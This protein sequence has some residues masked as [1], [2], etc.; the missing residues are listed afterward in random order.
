M[1]RDVARSAIRTDGDVLDVTARVRCTARER[2]RDPHLHDVEQPDEARHDVQDERRA[3]RVHLEVARVG[4]GAGHDGRRFSKAPSWLDG[5]AESR[6]TINWGREQNLDSP[7]V[8]P[9][10][11]QSDYVMHYVMHM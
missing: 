4:E 2:P 9:R 5:A 3:R 11:M 1:A 8:G 6:W 7:R 10:D